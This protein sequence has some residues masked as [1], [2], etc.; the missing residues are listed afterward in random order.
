M[1]TT[2]ASSIRYDDV[3]NLIHRIARQ[4]PRDDRRLVVQVVTGGNPT[5]VA[6][7]VFATYP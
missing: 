5:G 7:R 6:R 2:S 4:Y 1:N 3:L